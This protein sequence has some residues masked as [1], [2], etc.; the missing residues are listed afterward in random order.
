[1]FD[2]QLAFQTIVII[3]LAVVVANLY[4]AVK[5]LRAEVRDLAA[6]EASRG[7]SPQQ[8]LQPQPQQTNPPQPQP[9]PKPQPAPRQVPLQEPSAQPVFAAVAQ[10]KTQGPP[11]PRPATAGISPVVVQ[12]PTPNPA[13][14]A[15]SNATGATT[16]KGAPNPAQ[17]KPTRD[18][19]SLENV[20]G[21]RVLGIMAA[22]LV[23]AGLVFLSI[24]VMPA[25]TDEVRCAAM[26]VLSGALAAAGVF[27][28]HK[29]KTPFS[30]ALLGCGLGSVF[31]SLLV[32]YVH[33]GFLGFIT[34][35]ALIL[36]WL[37]VCTYLAMRYA[38][39]ALA[40]ITQVGM[41][42]SVCFAFAQGI[43]RGPQL[44]LVVVYQLMACAI[45]VVGCLRSLERGRLA[46]LFVSAFVSLC[47]SW[48]VLF[49]YVIWMPAPYQGFPFQ[50]LPF[51]LIMA[52]QF[53]CVSVLMLV[54]WVLTYKAPKAS[55]TKPAKATSSKATPAKVT[56]AMLS[57]HIAT[58][59]LWFVALLMDVL[60]T[61]L[62]AIDNTSFGS[63]VSMAAL[64]AVACVAAHWVLC[65]VLARQILSKKLAYMS[66]YV[67]ATVCT[68][69]LALRMFA[70]PAPGVLP[71]V[72]L[73]APALWAC[74]K[75]MD[76]PK[77]KVNA[78]AFVIADALLML[79]GGYEAIGR[80]SL[81]P[82][83][84]AYVLLLDAL[85]IAWWRTLPEKTRKQ[86]LS[87]ALVGGVY[88]TEISL[89][90]AWRACVEPALAGVT[91][92][93]CTLV[94]VAALAL[95]EPQRRWNLSPTTAYVLA[96]NEFVAVGL[97]S[98]SVLGN[99][100]R[101]YASL[102]AIAP[103][104]VVATA[105]VAFV[106]VAYRMLHMATHAKEYQ[107]WAQVLGGIA[108]MLWA[109][110][111]AQGFFPPS[112]E[113]AITVVAMLTA[114][115]CIVL[116]FARRLGTLRLYGLVASILCVLKIVLFDASAGD[117]VGRVIV[118]IVGGLICFAISALYT[119]AV[120]KL[121]V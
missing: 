16:A 22:L 23:F 74:G 11:P 95:F 83:A 6:R 117:S 19:G 56:S 79:V 111:T 17:P 5:A 33:F 101:W 20:V 14:A 44:P 102:S 26:F 76:E 116:G 112:M 78:I 64:I 97:C 4:M 119:Y 24:L 25:L 48:Q 96:V 70:A 30:Q 54:V 66:I 59:A 113:A 88:A 10:N 104:L 98:T 50:R 87:S 73:V 60:L 40:V 114:L 13:Q 85:L 89:F 75:M 47:V 80:D 34:T 46:G 99:G 15:P 1:M 3:V 108:L 9:Q 12:G 36:A 28:T 81:V 107:P 18:H 106:V 110:F 29:Q 37:C 57:T 93:L 91:G 62:V 58:E 41:A 118:L 8:Q 55:K 31:V 92:F 86:M 100:L 115:A 65:V 2:L 77:H 27:V 94:L 105:L 39:A 109:S 84:P 71:L 38:S 52:T 120:R 103:V 45:V 53:V 69:L 121:D 7:A 61:A 49:Y 82:L 67:C 43:P 63:R 72:V 68:L 35:L 32:A 21:T 90:F 51:V 42:T